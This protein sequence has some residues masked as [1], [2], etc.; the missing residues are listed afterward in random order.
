MC[1]PLGILEP[2]K[3]KSQED[4]DEINDMCEICKLRRDEDLEVDENE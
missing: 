4:I 1:M 3:I 2:R